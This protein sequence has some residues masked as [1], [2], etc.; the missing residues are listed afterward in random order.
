MLAGNLPFFQHLMGRMG[1]KPLDVSLIAY[2]LAHT[3]HQD[4]DVFLGKTIG[5]LIAHKLETARLMDEIAKTLK[6]AD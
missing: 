3:Y 6:D 2:D 5:D 1:E 4:P